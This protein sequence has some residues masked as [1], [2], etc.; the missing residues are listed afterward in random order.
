MQAYQGSKL[1]GKG[2]NKK[3]KQKRNNEIGISEDV[4]SLG[5]IMVAAHTHIAE[6]LAFLR[7]ISCIVFWGSLERQNQ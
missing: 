6:S 7:I 2:E 4:I 5:T 1:A 3:T